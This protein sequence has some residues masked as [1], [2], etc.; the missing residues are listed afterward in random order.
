[1]CGWLLTNS[2]ETILFRKKSDVYVEGDPTRALVFINSGKIKTFKTNKEGK[3]L[4]TGVYTKGNFIG[5]KDLIM[6]VR[7]TESAKT[8]EDSKLCFIPKKSFNSILFNNRAIANRTLKVLSK[9]LWQREE[10][11]IHLAYDS[12]RRR[13]AETLLGLKKQ[14]VSEDGDDSSLPISRKDLAK[15]VGTTNES[16]TRTISEFKEEGL[17]KTNKGNIIFMNLEGL[18]TILS[19][20]SIFA[21]V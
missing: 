5:Y 6:G 20:T 8:L 15:M 1:M 14:Y 10:Q 16:V 19:D 4:I 18:K 21:A 7:Y 17:L 9:S 13:V 11:L 2:T 12:V 3:E